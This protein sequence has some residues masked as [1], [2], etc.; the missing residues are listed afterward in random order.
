MLP[1]KDINVPL[2]ITLSRVSPSLFPHNARGTRWSCKRSLQRSEKF[3]KFLLIP[4]PHLQFVG[5]QCIS[6]SLSH[7]PHPHTL[8]NSLTWLTFIWIYSLLKFFFQYI[9]RNYSLCRTHFEKK[10]LKYSF[11]IPCS[12]NENKSELTARILLDQITFR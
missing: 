5:P 9:S 2:R 7:I 8:E 12:L 3:G 4:Y 1:F 10:C 6:D 11:S